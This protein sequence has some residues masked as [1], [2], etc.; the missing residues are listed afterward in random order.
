[1]PQIPTAPAPQITLLLPPRP[2]KAAKHKI[3]RTPP[4]PPPKPVRTPPPKPAP[5]PAPASAPPT[6]AQ[7][8]PGTHTLPPYPPM[9]RRLGH[10]GTVLLDIQ[11]GTDGRVTSASVAASS[12]DGGLDAAARAWVLSQWRYRPA[13]QNGS[14]ISERTRVKITFNLAE[15]P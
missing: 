9:A 7:A 5:A 4:P 12:G 13:T 3:R 14:P 1:M 6:P 15:E 2:A 11:I 8:I 10:Q